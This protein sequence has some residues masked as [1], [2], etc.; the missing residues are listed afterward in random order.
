MLLL[1]HRL[2]KLKVNCSYY[3]FFS[4]KK[5]YYQLFCFIHFLHFHL[6]CGLSWSCVRSE[7][8]NILLEALQWEVGGSYIYSFLL[9]EMPGDLNRKLHSFC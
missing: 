3:N 2:K 5:V 9:V 7:W 8:K 6:F 1:R 4:N